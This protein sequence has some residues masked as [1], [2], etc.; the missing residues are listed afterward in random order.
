MIQGGAS[1]FVVNGSSLK[2]CG[3]NLS[4]SGSFKVIA[5][6]MAAGIN[7]WLASGHGQSLCGNRNQQVCQQVIHHAPIY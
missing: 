6:S 7:T 1:C 3:E 2:H 4:S 5:M